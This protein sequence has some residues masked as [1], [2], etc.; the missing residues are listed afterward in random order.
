[1]PINKLRSETLHR[2]IHPQDK[3]CKPRKLT[4]K[5]KVKSNFISN[6]SQTYWD[7]CFGYTDK[8]SPFQKWQLFLH[9]D[10]WLQNTATLCAV[11]CCQLQTVLLHTGHVFLPALHC[12]L[13]WLPR[14]SDQHQK[15]NHYLEWI[16]FLPDKLADLNKLHSHTMRRC[17]GKKLERTCNREWRGREIPLSRTANRSPA[18]NLPLRSANQYTF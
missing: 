3:G 16:R 10:M 15:M 17:N 4:I 5:F 6:V 7:A 8:L 9:P 12:Q 1:M 11:G 2:C 13:T 14:K 18:E